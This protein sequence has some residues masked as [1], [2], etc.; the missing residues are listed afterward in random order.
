VNTHI[1]LYKFSNCAKIQK[2]FEKIVFYWRTLYIS[3]R[4]VVM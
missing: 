3:Y 1:G 4:I 2:F